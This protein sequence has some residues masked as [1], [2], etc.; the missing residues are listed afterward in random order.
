MYIRVEIFHESSSLSSF[1]LRSWTPSR[2]HAVKIMQTSEWRGHSS[3]STS[4][5]AHLGSDLDASFVLVDPNSS[6][7]LTQP[8]N[9]APAVPASRPVPPPTSLDP[10]IHPSSQPSN[11]KPGSCTSYAH[12]WSS[13]ATG[14]SIA[15]QGNHLVDQ[16][17]RVCLPRGVNLSGGCKSYVPLSARSRYPV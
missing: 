8:S 4:M 15:I 17:G 3:A 16:Y 14:G 11:Y 12:D 13:A 5:A 7:V 9:S 10:P 6:V 1:S 2:L